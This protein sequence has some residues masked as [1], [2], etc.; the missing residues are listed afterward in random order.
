MR[1]DLSIGPARGA[2]GAAGAP[3]V[4]QNLLIKTEQFDSAPWT[5]VTAAV[6]VP[7]ITTDPLGGATADTITTPLLNNGLAQVSATTATTGAIAA[8]SQGFQAD[9]VWERRSVTGSFDSTA[10]VF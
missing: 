2:S 9:Q 6:V 5:P 3:V 10:Y 4:N 8:N 1:I 7:N